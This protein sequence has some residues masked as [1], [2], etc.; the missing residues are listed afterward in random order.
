MAKPKVDLHIAIPTTLAFPS[1]QD[2]ITDT[3][4]VDSRFADTCAVDGCSTTAPIHTIA[5]RRLSVMRVSSNDDIE[6]YVLPFSNTNTN[7]TIS[8]TMPLHDGYNGEKER[9]GIWG[10]VWGGNITLVWRRFV[11]RLRSATSTATTMA[12]AV[13]VATV[14]SLFAY[15]RYV[16]S[17]LTWPMAKK[18]LRAA[19]AYWLAFLIELSIPIMSAIGPATFLAV[20]AVVYFQPAR[21]CGALWE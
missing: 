12:T 6:N 17:K 18:V 1:P 20:V 8:S 16:R 14:T 5:N 10:R 4:T 21:T 3:C 7:N 13:N 19:V 2:P 9:R 15:A 11:D